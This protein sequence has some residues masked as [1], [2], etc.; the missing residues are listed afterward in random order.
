MVAFALNR[1]K[2]QPLPN[3]Q[4]LTTLELLIALEDF[5]VV[6]IFVAD[7][8][9]VMVTLHNKLDLPPWLIEEYGKHRDDLHRHLRRVHRIAFIGVFL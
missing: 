3:P 6:D 7:G 5:G 2:T 4:I 9:L 1:R 8:Q